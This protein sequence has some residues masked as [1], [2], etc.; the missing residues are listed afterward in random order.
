MAI[1]TAVDILAPDT[2][3][4]VTPE[5]PEAWGVELEPDSEL[6]EVVE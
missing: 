5:S 1:M 4:P 3:R 6:W 2:A